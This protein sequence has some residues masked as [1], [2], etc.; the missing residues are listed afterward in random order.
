VRERGRD[1]G[2]VPAVGGPGPTGDL[3]RLRAEYGIA[4]G[5]YV[6]RRDEETLQAAYE[7]GR[8]GLVEGVNVLDL[9]Q[10]HHDA[11]LRVLERPREGEELSDLVDAG[12]RFFTEV[13]GAVEMTRRGFLETRRGAA[14]PR[15]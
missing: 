15:A 4:F 5:R 10:V 2:G 9:V 12:A 6:S 8:A 13:L 1:H 3:D 14:P 11:L 7:L